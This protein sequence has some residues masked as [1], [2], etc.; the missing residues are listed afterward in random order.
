VTTYRLFPSTSGPGSPTSY[1]GPWLAGV[2][3]SPTGE[4]L[5]LNGYYWWAPAGGDTTP[6]KFALWNRYSD[7]QQNLVPNSTV[8]SGTLTLGQWNFTALPAPIQ[9][10]PGALYVAAAGYTATNGVPITSNQWGSAEP[11]AGGIVNG[12]LTGWSDTSGTN[13]FPAAT[14]NHNLNQG[15][16]STSLGSDPSAAMPNAGSNSDNFWVDVQVTPTAPGGYAGSYRM[17]PNLAEVGNYTLDT[18]NN[19]T[20]GA[21]FSLTQACTVNNVW[22]YSP[23]TVTQLPTSIGVYQISNTTLIGSNVSPSWSGAAASGWISAA[24]PGVTL[25]AGIPYKVVVCNGAG[26][27]SAWNATVF[28]YWDSTGF[29]TNGLTAGPISMPNLATA[30]SPGQDTYNPGATLTF[31]G[32]YA[33][34]AQSYGLDIEVTPQSAPPPPAQQYVYQMRM[35]P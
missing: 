32:T 20:L 30:Q 7:T 4:M 17:Y 34:P 29:G 28:D 24:L 14:V 19:F 26:S 15:V 5:W 27:P 31:P 6:V 3:F 21:E 18:A 13:A 12:P 25:Q 10:A 35:M 11:L 1:S 22:F 2:L 33:P 9:I 16:F 8:T 23:A